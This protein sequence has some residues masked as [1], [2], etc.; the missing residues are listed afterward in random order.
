M[1]LIQWTPAMS[2][3]MAELD[4]DHKQLIQVIN[5]LAESAGD[6][7]R[8][9]IVR[10]CLMALRRYAERH[11]AREEKVLTVCDFPGLDVQRSEHGDFIERL[12]KVTEH[13][14]AEPEGAASV[15]NEELLSFLKSWWN[16]H[17]LIEDMAYRP[18]V[19]NSAEAKKAAK[20]FQ[21]TEIWWSR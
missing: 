14:D 11:F 1:T 7:T 9:A 21:A 15:V 18:F 13:F 10:Q 19:E 20:N 3:G 17:I 16:H 12:R 6:R 2:V 5:Q 8:S 4:D